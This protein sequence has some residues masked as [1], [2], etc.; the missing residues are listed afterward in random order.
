MAEQ[1]GVKSLDIGFSLP[2]LTVMIQDNQLILKR[3]SDFCISMPHAILGHTYAVALRFVVY[4]KF[5]L[6]R[7]SC[8]LSGHSTLEFH[9]S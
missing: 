5:K 4:L 2:D 1:S 8:I 7:A 9:R 6:T 3:K